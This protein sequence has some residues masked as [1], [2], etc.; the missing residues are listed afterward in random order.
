[1]LAKKLV[2]DKED[3]TNVRS[4]L[5]S[6]LTDSSCYKAEK[7]LSRLPIDGIY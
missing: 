7:I 6:F 2:V 4:R 3:T 1:M 5:I